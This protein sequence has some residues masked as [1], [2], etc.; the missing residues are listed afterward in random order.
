[1]KEFP[2][3]TDPLGYYVVDHDGY[4]VYADPPQVVL[5]GSAESSLDHLGAH[6]KDLTR[7]ENWP[8][9]QAGF[10]TAMAGGNQTEW[11]T[12]GRETDHGAL[13]HWMPWRDPE[14]HDRIL[15][16]ACFVLVTPHHALD[17]VRT[18][19]RNGT[20]LRSTTNPADPAEDRPG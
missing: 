3:A 8:L 5:Q 6:W 15:G 11:I 18:Q 12:G 2:P 14:D 13:M 19:L 20:R 7:E 16:V 10:D 17:A 9:I 4:F 1:M